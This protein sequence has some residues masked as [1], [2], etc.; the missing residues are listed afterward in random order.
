MK[1]QDNTHKMRLL[2]FFA[3]FFDLEEFIITSNFIPK[4]AALSSTTTLRLCCILTISSTI[5]CKYALQFKIGKHQTFSLIIMGIGSIITVILGIIFKPKEYNMGNYIGS[6]LLA[7]LHFIF[8]SFTDCIEKY[9]ADYDYVNPFQIIMTEGIISFVMSSIYSTIQ[10][11][12]REV[13]IIYNRESTS[14]FILLLVLL[15][16]YSVLSGFVNIYK[17]VC[18]VLYSPMTKSLASYFL[19]SPFIIYH[20]IKGNDFLIEGESNI[21]YFIISLIITIIT[22]FLGLIYYEF[23]I[24]NCCGL[25][26]ET[27]EGISSRVYTELEM[28]NNENG[29]QEISTNSEED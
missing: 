11:P 26:A 16:I 14:K 10:N 12:F 9:L 19:I 20:F 13:T 5:I 22:G 15:F 29:S 6:Y 7:F 28:I 27:Y 3:S 2:V 1:I 4:V 8:T 18:N 21:Y 23:F 24:L 25:S 17:I